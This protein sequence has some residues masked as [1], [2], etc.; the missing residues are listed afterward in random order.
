VTPAEAFGRALRKRRKAAAL[1]QEKVALAADLERVFVS[2]LENG[3]Q[4]PG[5]ETMLKLARALDCK[6]ADIVRD[7]EALIDAH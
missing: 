4:Q 6:A 7:A 5:F 3:K 2:W 1:T